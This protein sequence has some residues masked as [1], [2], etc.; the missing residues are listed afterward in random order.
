MADTLRDLMK[1]ENPEKFAGIT[2]AVGMGTGLLS[3]LMTRKGPSAV[4]SA[5]GGMGQGAQL[6][7]SVGGPW[8]AVIG[9]GLGAIAGAFSGAKEKRAMEAAEANQ[10][11]MEYRASV[12]NQASQ[13]EIEGQGNGY[14]RHG[15]KIT[16]RQMLVKGGKLQPMSTRSMEAIGKSHEQGGIQLEGG[17]IEGGETI[18][19]DNYVFSKVLGFADAHKRLMKPAAKIEQKALTSERVNSLKD[20]MKREGELKHKQELLKSL[21]NA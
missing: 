21:I 18:T 11:D 8:G 4:G 5:V 15:G 7:L 12:H 6:G 13:S 3:G 2:G 9:G 17:E 20:I 14:Y 1:G 19:S 16:L 10:R